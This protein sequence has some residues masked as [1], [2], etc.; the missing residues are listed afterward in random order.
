MRGKVC[1]VTG[2]NRGVGRAVAEGLARAG[3]KVFI[4][5]RTRE[6]ADH[7]VSEIRA[8]TGN[9]DVHAFV[10]DLAVRAEVRGLVE[11]VTA[12]TN[13]LHVL[14]NNAGTFNTYRTATP[15]GVEATFA[16]NHLAPFM[17]TRG[18]KELLK[19]SAPARVINIASDTHQQVRDVE[20][21]ESRKGYTGFTAYARSKLAMVMFTYDLAHRLEGTGVTVNACTPGLVATGVLENIFDRWWT[22]WAWP[23]AKKFTISVED[24][25]A[26]PLYLA[27]SPEV[28]GVTGKYFK[29]LRPATTSLVSHDPTIGARLWNVSLRMTGELPEVEITG[30]HIAA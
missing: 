9:P 15:D 20:D 16:V 19:A 14:V 8:S 27:T 22:K 30:E 21:W 1:L 4:T 5:A 25:A 13:Q 3:A 23:I 10:A 26:T 6:K 12:A 7:T 18:L 29:K 17:L 11:Q 2:A 28:E 24:G